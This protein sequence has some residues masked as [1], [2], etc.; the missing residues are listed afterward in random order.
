MNVLCFRQPVF[1]KRCGKMPVSANHLSSESQGAPA[2]TLP[3]DS[4]PSPL[5]SRRLVVWTEGKGEMVKLTCLGFVRL[6]ELVPRHEWA[7]KKNGKEGVKI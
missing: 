6:D 7:K 4:F 3:E 1:C 5:L 2:S